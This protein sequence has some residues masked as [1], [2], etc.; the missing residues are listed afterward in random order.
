MIPDEWLAALADELRQVGV[1]ADL[2]GSV[3]AEAATHLRDSGA[4]PASV[5]GLPG[6]YARAVA[7]RS[8]GRIP[9]HPGGLPGRYDSR[10]AASPRRTV[11]GRSSRAWI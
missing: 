11:V 6:E 5:F 8:A 7:E 9:G 2:A 3:V 10:R 4:P 1:H